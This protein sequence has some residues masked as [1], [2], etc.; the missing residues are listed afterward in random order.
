MAVYVMMM[1]IAALAPP[2]GTVDVCEASI[3]TVADDVVCA[4]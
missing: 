2:T 4:E 1:A 3:S